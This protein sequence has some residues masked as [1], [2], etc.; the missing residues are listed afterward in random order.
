VLRGVQRARTDE[1]GALHVT[2]LEPHVDYVVCVDAPPREAK[3]MRSR[4][5]I[6]GWIEGA[7]L[8]DLQGVKLMA[9]PAVVVASPA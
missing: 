1:L 6:V 8:G 5:D 7:V 3:A 2:G 4:E 9:R